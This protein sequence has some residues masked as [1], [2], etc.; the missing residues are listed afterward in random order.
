MSGKR[1]EA[2]GGSDASTFPLRFNFRSLGLTSYDPLPV[3]LRADIGGIALFLSSRAASHITGVIIPVDGG[4]SLGVERE[5]VKVK[6]KA[7]L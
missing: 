3:C 6:A 2:L 1:R 5:P 4:A 7:K